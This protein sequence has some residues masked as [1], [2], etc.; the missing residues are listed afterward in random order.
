VNCRKEGTEE[1]NSSKNNRIFSYQQGTSEMK[2][3]L[4]G[5]IGEIQYTKNHYRRAENCPQ[6]MRLSPPV[7]NLFPINR[8]NLAENPGK[9][10]QSCKFKY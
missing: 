9:E 3:K 2:V 7:P 1:K 10:L 4:L 6:K 8:P 5:C